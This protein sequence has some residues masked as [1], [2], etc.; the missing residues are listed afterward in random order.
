MN[1]I[2]TLRNHLFD[3][4]DRLKKIKGDELK[5]EIEKSKAIIGI[6]SEILRSATTE[7]EIIKSVKELASGFVPDIIG[8]AMNTQIEDKEKPYQFGE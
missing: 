5:D 3:Q 4:L 2:T 8:Q 1:N 6:S 7:A